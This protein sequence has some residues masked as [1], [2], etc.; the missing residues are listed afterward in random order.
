MRVIKLKEE[1]TKT[2]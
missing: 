1:F 2:P